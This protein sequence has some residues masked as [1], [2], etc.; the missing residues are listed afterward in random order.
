ISIQDIT[1]KEIERLE[2]G[3]IQNLNKVIDLSNLKTGLYFL[4]IDSE[5]GRISKKIMKK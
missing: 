1:G 5:E 3:K 2:S 4:T